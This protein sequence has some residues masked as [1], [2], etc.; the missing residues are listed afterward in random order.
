[1][2]RAICLRRMVHLAVTT[3]HLMAAYGPVAMRGIRMVAGHFHLQKRWSG[4]VFCT[5]R[6]LCGIA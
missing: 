4:S 1:M 3:A 2:E 6:V 5:E